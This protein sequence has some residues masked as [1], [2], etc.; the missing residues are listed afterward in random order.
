MHRIDTPSAAPGN[1]F[2]EGSP[3]LGV[4]GTAVSAAFLNAL[5]E[6]IAG[7]IEGAA[8]VL[9]KPNNGQLLQAIQELITGGGA[10][11]SPYVKRDGTRS[12]SGALTLSGNASSALHAVPKQQLDAAIAPLYPVPTGA[13]VAFAMSDPWPSGWLACDGGAYS[14]STY[15]ALFAMI[16]TTYGAGNGSTTFNVPDL[17]GEFVRGLDLGRGVDAGRGLGTW[18]ADEVRSHTHDMGSEAGGSGNY[19]TPV[20]SGGVDETLAGNPTSAYGGAET[21]PRNVALM[22][23]IRT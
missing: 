14:R 9:S 19:T 23:C 10:D 1:Q 13:V 22:Y 15:S 5:Q 12:M 18:Q 16:G 6:E 21:R 3:G 4:P 2:T 8:I 20:D 7:V 17:R 11:L